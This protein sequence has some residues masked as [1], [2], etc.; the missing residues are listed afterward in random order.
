MYIHTEM[1]ACIHMRAQTCVHTH[2]HIHTL[3]M[4]A[5]QPDSKNPEFHTL[6]KA[7]NLTTCALALIA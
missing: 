2:E 4:N 5:H 7:K 6:D 1:R 3:H